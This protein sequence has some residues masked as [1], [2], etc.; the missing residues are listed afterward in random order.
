M[1]HFMC[2]RWDTS[3]HIAAS[4]ARG[5]TDVAEEE[6]G[7]VLKQSIPENSTETEEQTEP[8]K[9]EDASWIL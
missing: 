1:L 5:Y 8:A 6:F 2:Y 4:I 3:K 9:P 7:N